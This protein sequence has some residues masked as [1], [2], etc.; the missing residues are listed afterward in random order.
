MEDRIGKFWT[1]KPII[2]LS[3][4]ENGEEKLYSK[5]NDSPQ[6]VLMVPLI[7]VLT[8]LPNK[9]EEKP[10]S[11]SWMSEK[12]NEVF[13]HE[14]ISSQKIPMDLYKAVLK[15]LSEIFWQKAKNFSLN[16]RKCSINTCFK[17]KWFSSKCS[18][19]Q[20]ERSSDNPVKKLR[21]NYEIFSVDVQKWY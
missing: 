13:L 15:A 18:H 5:T 21:Q 11:F 17:N 4:S 12:V 20:V 2:F 14:E 7:A 6:N 10:G 9:S 8:T 3:M 1:K 16:V 19:G